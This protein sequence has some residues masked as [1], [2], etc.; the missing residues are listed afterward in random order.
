MDLLVAG[1]GGEVAG[2]QRSEAVEVL[3]E[4]VQAPRRGVVEWFAVQAGEPVG[5]PA[6][7]R[8][9]P[10]VAPLSGENHEVI[11]AL[12]PGGDDTP[13]AHGT[14]VAGRLLG[15]GQ[16]ADGGVDAVRAGHCSASSGAYPAAQRDRQGQPGDAA[17][18]DQDAAGFGH[19]ILPSIARGGGLGL[20]AG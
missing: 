12:G 9:Q 4:P 14:R 8:D 10:E 16:A 20:L 6:A 19:V 13:P 5:V 15:H 11:H 2:N 18:G 3:P 1:Q 17:A 7:H